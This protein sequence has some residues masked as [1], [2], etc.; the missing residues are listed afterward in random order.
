MS[1][2]YNHKIVDHSR[3]EYVNLQDNSIHSNSIEGF[4]GIFKR[5]MIG[6]YNHT[7]KGHL[8]LYVNEFVYRYKMRKYPDGDKFNWMIT[9][10][11]VR[12]KYNDIKLCVVKN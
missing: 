11:G 9:N 4:W 10:S 3:K 6:I 1:S 8:P 7:S 2:I 12:T 5:G